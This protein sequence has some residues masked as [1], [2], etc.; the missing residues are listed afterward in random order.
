MIW[1]AKDAL[2]NA[3]ETF[4]LPIYMN[5]KGVGLAEY[6]LGCLFEEHIDVLFPNNKLDKRTQSN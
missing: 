5:H 1:K 2:E 6:H 4:K 3:I